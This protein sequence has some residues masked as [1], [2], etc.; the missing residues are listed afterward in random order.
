MD[1]FTCVERTKEFLQELERREIKKLVKLRDQAEKQESYLFL[2]EKGQK[3][4][5]AVPDVLPSQYLRQV[6]AVQ[7]ETPE[8]WDWRTSPNI[9]EM[10]RTR[11]RLRR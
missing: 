1:T 5:F 4:V 2:Q 9:E 8:R 3:Y 7:L 6:I 11:E 10:L